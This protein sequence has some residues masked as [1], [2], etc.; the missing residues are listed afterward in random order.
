MRSSIAAA[1][2]I[3]MA[4]AGVASA[5]ILWDQ[6]AIDVS[7]TGVGM[8]NSVSGGFNGWIAFGVSDVTVPA[9][10]WTIQSITTYFSALSWNQGDVTQ[11]VLNVFPK[12]GGAPVPG[13]DPRATP[14]GSGTLVGVSQ[15]GASAGGNGV[16]EIM[17]SGLSIALAP[18]DYWVGL[19]P[20]GPAG[21]FGPDMQWSTPT[22]I[23]AGQQMRLFGPDSGWLDVGATYGVP[24]VDGAILI[25]GAVPAPASLALLGLG[26]LLAGRRRRA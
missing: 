20:V 7:P 22:R 26:G 11:A 10:G 13:N 25:Q 8:P 15:T 5:D 23:G 3:L 21:P 4:V 1:A 24:A 2:A 17:A 16:W 19:T 9:S 18:G 14:T 12:T 6:S